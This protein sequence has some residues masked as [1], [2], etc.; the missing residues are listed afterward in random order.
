MGR[1]NLFRILDLREITILYNTLVVYDMETDGK[2]P[3]TCQPIQIAAV[4]INTRNLEYYRTRS[5]D[6]VY[7]NSLMRPDL[8]T[9]DDSST[10]IHGKTREMLEKAPL[11]GPVWHDFA[12]FVHQFDLKG[13]NDDFCSPVPC[14]FNI[15]NYDSIIVDRL[16]E[17][18]KIVRDNGKQAIFN[19]RLSFDVMQMV[20]EWFWWSKEP[21]SISMDNLRKF[22]GMSK[23]G[24][25]DAL[26]DVQDTGDILIR[27]LGLTEEMGKRV[28]FRDCFGKNPRLISCQNPVAVS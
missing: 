21:A 2:N 11:P 8:E 5:G 28:K 19:S 1:V 7:F 18:Y 16:C 14:G 24:A 13:K 3:R 4:V 17:E 26:K 12:R 15:N 10:R 25:H 27:F 22:F 23:E 9:F 6:L 20:N